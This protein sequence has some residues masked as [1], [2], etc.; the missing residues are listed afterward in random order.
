MS[1]PGR[2]ERGPPPQRCDL[3][4]EKHQQRRI[5]DKDIVTTR[6]RRRGWDYL[7]CGELCEFGFA[8]MVALARRAVELKFE[9]HRRGW[10]YPRCA[11]HISGLH[12]RYASTIRA[13]APGSQT[14]VLIPPTGHHLDCVEPPERVGFE[15]TVGARPTAVFKTAAFNRSA[16]SPKALPALCGPSRILGSAPSSQ[17]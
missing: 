15:P 8:R 11:L 13:C 4:I 5:G 3:V 9:S 7:A 2:A 16:T 1:A 14:E 17:R 10:D 6:S 12:L